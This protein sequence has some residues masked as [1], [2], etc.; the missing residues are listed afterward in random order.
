VPC[1]GA[2]GTA[3]GARAPGS[4]Q[5]RS[6]ASGSHSPRGPLVSEPRQLPARCGSG[7]RAHA[8]PPHVRG[9]DTGR[10]RLPTT[11]EGWWA[12]RSVFH[13]CMHACV[14]VKVQ[15]HSGHLV[16]L[17]AAVKEVDG[18]GYSCLLIYK[19]YFSVFFWGSECAAWS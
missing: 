5:I 16:V 13:A 14:R 6:R 9:T 19:I 1:D 3:A 12:P 8:T 11:G 15:K 7:A 10:T 17:H 4:S 18:R 2:R